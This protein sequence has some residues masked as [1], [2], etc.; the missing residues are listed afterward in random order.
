[1]GTS[2]EDFRDMVRRGLIA[3]EFV[4]VRFE[5]FVVVSSKEVRGYYQDEFAAQFRANNQVIPPL[6][7]VE[8][9][10]RQ[11]LA[12]RKKNA[13]VEE[14]IRAARRQI[15]VDVLLF[16]SPRFSPNLPKSLRGEEMEPRL[17][18]IAASH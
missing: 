10:I 16:R 11:I 18:S 3:N 12:N 2:R 4:K 13:Q 6:T 17:I 7:L 5:P 15:E 1:M 14:W 9:S 8:E